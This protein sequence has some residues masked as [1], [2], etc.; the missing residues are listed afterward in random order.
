VDEP[1]PAYV[2]CP[3][4]GHAYVLASDLLDAYREITD[5]GPLSRPAD[6]LS[7][8]LCRHGLYPVTGIDR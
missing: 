3:G 6:I 7:C 8:P 1:E 5:D 2:I 4:C